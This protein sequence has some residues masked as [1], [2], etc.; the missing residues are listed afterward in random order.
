MLVGIG[1]VSRAGKT[2]LAKKLRLTLGEENCNIISQDDYLSPIDEIPTIESNLDWEHPNSIN[3]GALEKDLQASLENFE[4][5]I[6]EG[7]FA[8]QSPAI[9][10]RFDLFIYLKISKSTFE[11]RKSEDQRWGIVSKRYMQHI[12]DSHQRYALKKKS[13]NEHYFDMDNTDIE[14]VVREIVKNMI[15]QTKL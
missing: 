8:F 4:H 13:K 10:K 7:I 1:G 11:K 14:A 3:Y 5:T 6:L 15:T 12:W 9:N 2:K